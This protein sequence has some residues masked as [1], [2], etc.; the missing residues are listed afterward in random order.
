M[1]KL[2]AAIVWAVIILGFVLFFVFRNNTPT[3][4]IAYISSGSDQILP[5]PQISS[6][7]QTYQIADNSVLHWTGTKPAGAHY[8]TVNI[9]DGA[10]AV[11]KWRIVAGKFIIDMPSLQSLDSEG[12][13]KDMLENHLKT[14]F[15]DVE[16]FPTSTFVIKATD[17]ISG[18]L[19]IIGD[20][21]LKG[22]TKQ[23]TFPADIDYEDD[24]V[25]T[26]AHFF[27]D[28]REWGVNEVL[29]IADKYIEFGLDLVFKK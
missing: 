2:I 28:R 6:K 10:I 27:I 4:H 5:I 18:Q 11:E 3:S 22:V 21:T 13:T 16:K 1:K 24:S 14:W 26:T 7:A 12:K 17:R 20:L 8:G 25:V 23:I 15:F 9:I 29:D 19:Y